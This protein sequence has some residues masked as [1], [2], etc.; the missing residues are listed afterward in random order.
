MQRVFQIMHC[1]G[2]V[3]WNCY[4]KRFTNNY[5]LSLVNFSVELE[6]SSFF[7]THA[8]SSS[9]AVSTLMSE[10]AGRV[11]QGVTDE[12]RFRQGECVRRLWLFHI[13]RRRLVATRRPQLLRLFTAASTRRLLPQKVELQVRHVTQFSFHCAFTYEVTWGAILSVHT[14]DALRYC[15]KTARHIIE[16]AFHQSRRIAFVNFVY[17]STLPS[18]GN[19]YA[20]FHRGPIKCCSSSV[21]LSVWTSRDADFL[22]MAKP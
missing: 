3:S 20:A 16:N 6:P 18:H 8:Y 15:V 2:G 10:G 9:Q 5:V 4:L 21:C 19:L 7:Y 12:R 11:Q 22:E 1:G 13:P 14:S 17:R